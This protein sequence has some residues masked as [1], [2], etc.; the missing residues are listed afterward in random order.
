[1]QLIT[2]TPS[3]KVE[4]DRRYDYFQI[5]RGIACLMVFLNHVVGLL[6]GRI[7]TKGYWYDPLIVPLGFPWVWLFLIL[8][9]FLLTKQFVDGRMELNLTGILNFYERRSRRL[10]PMLWF[11][12]LLLGFLYG[13]H[14]WSPHLPAFS[15]SAELQVALALPWVPYIQQGNPVASVNSPVWS[16]V[17]EIHYFLLLP[18]ILWLTR[19][20]SRTMLLLVGIWM[21]GIAGL[22][23]RVAVHRSPDI[24]PMIYQEH[25]YNCGFMLAG[26]AIALTK[27]RPYKVSWRWPILVV[28]LLIV[29]TQYVT[30]YNLN[31]ALA[32]LPIAALPGFSL[33]VVKANADFQSPIPKSIRQLHL[34]RGPLRWFELAGVMSYSIYLLHK[35]LSYIVIA[36]I[37]L[38]HWVTGPFSLIAMTLLTAAAIFPPILLSFACVEMRFRRPSNKLLSKIKT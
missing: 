18:V 32:L 14:I 24:F 29:G 38:D 3:S 35:P 6:S 28:V 37:G 15:P 9:G 30:A 33:L 34:A 4:A 1:M 16:A 25:L 26:C 13:L 11:V 17:L 8:S 19:M 27:L 5:M 2:E 22:A 10:L 36:Q 12:P 7:D 20:S 23:F 31:L 21:I